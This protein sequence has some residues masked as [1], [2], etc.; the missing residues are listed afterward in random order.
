[1]LW[2]IGSLSAPTFLLPATSTTREP[3]THELIGQ[4]RYFKPWVILNQPYL[5]GKRVSKLLL[6]SSMFFWTWLNLLKLDVMIH[7]KIKNIKSYTS[8]QVKQT[9]YDDATTV[10]F[11]IHKSTHCNWQREETTTIKK[12]KSGF[13][14]FAIYV[15]LYSYIRDVTK[16]KSTF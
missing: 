14:D 16:E 1:M 4:S 9:A 13:Y 8:T 2:C 3:F 11:L 15:L 5:Q 10:S 7:F 6:S 12:K